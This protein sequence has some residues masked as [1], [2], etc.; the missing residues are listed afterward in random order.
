MLCPG[1]KVFFL[2]DVSGFNTLKGSKGLIFL[3]LFICLNLFCLLKKR[4]HSGTLPNN[5][6]E[7]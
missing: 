7:A 6:V 4:V 3:N 1:K 2:F 5:P